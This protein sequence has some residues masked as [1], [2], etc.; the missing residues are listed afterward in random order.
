MLTSPPYFNLEIYAK[1]EQQ[2]ENQ[3]DT[4]TKWKDNWLKDVIEQGISRLNKGGHS[5]WNVHSVKNM[6]MVEDVEKIH[7]KLD[8]KHYTDIAL[9]S[10]RRQANQSKNKNTKNKD[11]T[12]IFIHKS[13][14]YSA[15]ENEFLSFFSG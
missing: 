14:K 2:S 13:Q 6:P 3:Y 9:S 7:K 5:A 11:L 12:R 4:Y 1:G 10:S 8:F 15:R